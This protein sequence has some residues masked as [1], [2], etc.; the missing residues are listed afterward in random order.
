METGTGK[1]YVYIKTMFELPDM[2]NVIKVTTDFKTGSNNGISIDF[3]LRLD[4]KAQQWKA[5]DMIIEG[6]SLINSK[7]A[8]ITSRI[9]ASDIQTVT[10]EIA[11]LARQ[12]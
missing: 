12:S 11:K 4:K 8:E 7:Q 2:E 1:T 10:L 3:K 9:R 6:I 5:F